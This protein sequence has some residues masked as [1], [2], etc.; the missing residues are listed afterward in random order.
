MLPLNFL[1]I[2]T[3]V[4]FIFLFFNLG[5]NVCIF[6]DSP[7]FS[8]YCIQKS[9]IDGPPSPGHLVPSHLLVTLFSLHSVVDIQTIS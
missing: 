9:I 8:C 5:C 2:F 4:V 3:L 1:C 7:F 6:I